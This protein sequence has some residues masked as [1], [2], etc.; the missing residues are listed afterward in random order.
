MRRWDGLAEA[1]AEEPAVQV[2]VT[3]IALSA[4]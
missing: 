2:V 3:F 1:Y 4:K